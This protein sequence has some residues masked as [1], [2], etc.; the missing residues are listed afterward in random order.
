MAASPPRTA[1]GSY[2]VVLGMTWN[3][4]GLVVFLFVLIT[5]WGVL[6]RLGDGLGAL[7]G[8]DEPSRGP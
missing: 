4:I 5:S 2:G 1:C 7:F 6:A 3:E 8:G